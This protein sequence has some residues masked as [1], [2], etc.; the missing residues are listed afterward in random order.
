MNLPY[1]HRER[2]GRGRRFGKQPHRRRFKHDPW[3]VWNMAT[4]NSEGSM[5]GI[6][7]PLR[8]SAIVFETDERVDE[9]LWSAYERND[10][11][12]VTQALFQRYL[13]QR[14]KDERRREPGC[15]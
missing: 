8:A 13:G 6:S 15:G 7:D 1:L 3:L 11:G 2:T 14:I 9:A 5:S 4:F 12:A 10:K